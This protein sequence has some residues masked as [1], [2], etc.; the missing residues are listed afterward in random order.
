LSTA[1]G[2][3]NASAIVERHV[4]ASGLGGLAAYAFTPPAAGAGAE[5]GGDAFL[6]HLVTILRV[7]QTAEDEAVVLKEVCGR[8]RHHLHA[9]SVAFVAIRDARMQ[10]VA[11][12]GPRPESDIAER[13]IGAAIAIAPH[14]RDDRI[15]AAA[16]VIY[17]GAPV[18][19]VCARWTLGATYDTSRAAS[20][21]MMTAAA[22][23]PIVA[24]AVAKSEQPPPPDGSDLLGVSPAIVELRRHVEC[25]AAAP[26][27]VLI[28][29]S[30][31]R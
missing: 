3:A 6:E 7:C 14:R 25:A 9:V 19:A 11:V 12:D 1:A 15:E 26:F 4:A 18:A 8:V 28:D 29:G 20:V 27:A 21:L 17:G 10:V 24:V 22:A 30:M 13:A 2:A 23:A 16:P 5:R 31:R